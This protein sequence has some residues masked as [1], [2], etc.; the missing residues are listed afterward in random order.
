[1]CARGFDYRVARGPTTVSMSSYHRT[2][3]MPSPDTDTGDKATKK[4]RV[5]VEDPKQDIAASP[6]SG[7]V[8]DAI[9][10][11]VKVGH[12]M[13]NPKKSLFEH[14]NT[15]WLGGIYAFSRT[16][17]IKVAGVDG[18]NMFDIQMHLGVFPQVCPK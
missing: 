9:A 10:S 16:R 2:Q 14:P 7:R 13:K 11:S 4:R 3:V 1:M 8:L 15:S 6:S 12:K 18:A 17:V 5:E